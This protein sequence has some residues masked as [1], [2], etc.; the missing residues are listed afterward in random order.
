M[1]PDRMFLIAKRLGLVWRAL[2]D[3]GKLAQLPH[4]R[5]YLGRDAILRASAVVNASSRFCCVFLG[6]PK[7]IATIVCVDPKEMDE[8]LMRSETPNCRNPARDLCIRSMEL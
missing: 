7:S 5:C 3:G 6:E 2:T 1:N 8:K 4:P